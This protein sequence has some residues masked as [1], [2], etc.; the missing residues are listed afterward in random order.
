LFENIK[1]L[2]DYFGDKKSDIGL[3]ASLQNAMCCDESFYVRKIHKNSQ[4]GILFTGKI[5]KFHEKE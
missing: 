3:I 4:D 5:R 1:L 2:H